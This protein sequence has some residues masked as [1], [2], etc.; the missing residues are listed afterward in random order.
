MSQIANTTRITMTMTLSML[1]L[2]PLFIRGVAALPLTAVPHP[3]S[4]EPLCGHPC[5]TYAPS[6]SYQ[7]V[8]IPHTTVPVAVSVKTMT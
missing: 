3:V 5:L 8:F 7:N 6:S 1:I 2:T 4:S